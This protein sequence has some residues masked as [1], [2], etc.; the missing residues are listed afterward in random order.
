MARYA[1]PFAAQVNCPGTYAH[2][3][4]ASAL[5]LYLKRSLV[6][7]IALGAGFQGAEQTFETAG[8]REN[9]EF[10]PGLRRAKESER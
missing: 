7:L 9:K 3:Y 6:P 2:Q 1:D 10:C 5:I 4:I 8:T